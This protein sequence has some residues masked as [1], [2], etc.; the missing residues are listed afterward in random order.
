MPRGPK[1]RLV[2]LTK[3][4]SMTDL[5]EMID[6]TLP[7]PGKR[8]PYKKQIV[9]NLGWRKPQAFSARNLP[10]WRTLVAVVLFLSLR[11]LGRV[12]QRGRAQ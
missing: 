8:G 11:E 5:A 4:W 2:S 12:C 6:A 7:E 10:N 3:L 1:M 9:A